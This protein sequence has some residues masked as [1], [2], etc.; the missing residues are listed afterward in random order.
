MSNAILRAEDMWKDDYLGP[1]VSKYQTL[2]ES[3]VLGK[4]KQRTI[5]KVLQNPCLVLTTAGRDST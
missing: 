4:I 2:P 5:L 1:P 3:L